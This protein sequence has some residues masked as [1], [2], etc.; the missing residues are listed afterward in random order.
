MSQEEIFIPRSDSW[1][2]SR[3]LADDVQPR[4]DSCL[5]ERSEARQ[6][7]RGQT[8]ARPRLD[9]C[10]TKEWISSRTWREAEIFQFQYL[11]LSL[12]RISFPFQCSLDLL[13]EARGQW[14]PEVNDLNEAAS[15]TALKVSR[16]SSE[17]SR[18][19][20]YYFPTK[21]LEAMTSVR[22]HDLKSI[23]Y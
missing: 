16:S 8:S 9:S 2:S 19:Q 21:V 14:P 4:S 17:N 6:S 13:K 5:A 22:G 18:L 7:D 12:P 3:G 23:L 20:A 1:L 11:L 10:Q 15:P